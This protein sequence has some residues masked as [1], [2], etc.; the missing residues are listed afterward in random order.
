MVV[1]TTKEAYPVHKDQY[2]IYYFFLSD[3]NR[4]I[5][6]MTFALKPDEN[7]IDMNMAC[8]INSVSKILIF[9]HHLEWQALKKP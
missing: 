3:S 6:W 7:L 4:L 1:K 9:S 8:D 2:Q 5:E